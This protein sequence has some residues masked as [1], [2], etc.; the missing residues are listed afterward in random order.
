M[1]KVEGLVQSSMFGYL[2]LCCAICRAVVRSE[3]LGVPVL[4]G[5]HNPPTLVERLTEL[6]K[7]GG[8]I[9]P[10]AS[11]GTTGLLCSTTT[12]PQTKYPKVPSS[13]KSH[14]EAYTG[15]L[16]LLMKWIFDPYIQ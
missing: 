1:S 4:F 3:N 15:F 10:L 9:A 11:P 12:Q 5:E 13:N 16:K 8:A 14:L 2:W 7:S 6:P